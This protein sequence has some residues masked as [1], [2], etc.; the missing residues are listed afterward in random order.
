MRMI[1][2][3]I[4]PPNATDPIAAIIESFADAEAITG[5]TVQPPEE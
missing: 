4:V 2:S 1:T 3:S 5:S